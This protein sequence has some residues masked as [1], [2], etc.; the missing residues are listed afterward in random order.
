[1]S[2]P[3]RHIIFT[4]LVNLIFIGIAS[5]LFAQQD[6]VKLE[7]EK[8]KLEK[9]ISY[10]SKLIEETSKNKSATLSQ[11][12]LIKKNIKGREVLI[13]TMNKQIASIDDNLSV[14]GTKIRSNEKMIK[15]LKKEYHQM[16]L[17]YEKQRRS[18]NM[19]MFVFAS[20]SFHQAYSRIKYF[21]QFQNYRKLQINRIL[22]LQGELIDNKK[23]FVS[24]K[25]YKRL[26]KAKEET[27]K[28]KLLQEKQKS[29]KSLQNLSKKERELRKTLEDKK[30]AAV[31][32]TKAIQK[33]IEE[34]TR[35]DIA[36]ASN[37]KKTNSGSKYAALPMTAEESKLSN[38]FN[39]NK[40]KLP[41]PLAQGI[42]SE[43]YGD[44]PHPVL[45]NVTVRNNGINISTN[46]NQPIKCVFDGVVTAIMFIEGF[47]NT[48]I[49][50]H[51]EFRTVY[52]NIGKLQVKK[53]E[54]VKTGQVIGY[55]SE[56]S[57]SANGE[58]HFE[59]WRGKDM[60]NPSGWLMT[61]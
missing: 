21:R 5:H 58:L 51:G 12:K 45:K 7:K 61:R 60:Q 34:E 44:H 4:L 36:N 1:M 39:E 6:R 16:V 3:V 54:K 50:R 2:K 11:L 13:N 23:L 15:E 57:D 59:L 33:A 14:I 9:E 42:V 10:T 55:V 24:E 28:L 22:A 48:V 19:L 18:N 27:V 46:R 49:I 17:A 25:E 20:E 37:T 35:K 8:S 38:S 32:L 56:D 41:W 26:V 29:D 52:S 47:Q 31:K 40:G 30:I 43:N 53:D